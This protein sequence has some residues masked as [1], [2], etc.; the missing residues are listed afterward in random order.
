MNVN[1]MLHKKS[2]CKSGYHKAKRK[3]KRKPKGRCVRT[4]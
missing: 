3:W 1:E 4:R 2:G